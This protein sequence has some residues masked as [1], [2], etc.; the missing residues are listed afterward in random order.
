MTNFNSSAAM[1]IALNGS[2]EYHAKTASTGKYTPDKRLNAHVQLAARMNKL[3][4]ALKQKTPDSPFIVPLQKSAEFIDQGYPASD[5]IS[6]I[7]SDKEMAKEAGLFVEDVAVDIVSDSVLNA[8]RQKV[9]A[10]SKTA[11]AQP[12][13]PRQVSPRVQAAWNRLNRLQQLIPQ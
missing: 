8:F 1:E 2:K 10:Y 12:S 5:V 6:T 4:C 11:S 13:A 9:T 7:F 3:A